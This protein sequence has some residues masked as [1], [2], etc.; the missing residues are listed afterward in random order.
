MLDFWQRV[1][2]NQRKREVTGKRVTRKQRAMFRQGCDATEFHPMMIFLLLMD[3]FN[4]EGLSYLSVS[5]TFSSI[6]LKK[7]L[8]LLT[9]VLNS[10]FITSVGVS[11]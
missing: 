11:T 2:T 7:I 4:I 1:C 3:R 10:T 9:P 6:N 5:C 8:R